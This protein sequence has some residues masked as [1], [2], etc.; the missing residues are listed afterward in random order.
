MTKHH[1]LGSGRSED[2][3][4]VVSLHVAPEAGAAMVSLQR[5]RALK[6]VGVEGDRYALKRGRFSNAPGSFTG[7]Q[8]TFIALEAIASLQESGIRFELGEAR[9]NI[10]T[11]GVS[12][13]SLVDRTFQIGEAVFRGMRLFQPCTYLERLT[14]VGVREA[15]WDR[16]GLRA[17]VVR[18]GE[19]RTGDAIRSL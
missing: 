17:D 8:V 7:R 12:L 6:G 10:V 19:I 2:L 1:S 3:G 16:G 15:L 14:A 5:A 13:A 18:G 4:R 9:R 11:E